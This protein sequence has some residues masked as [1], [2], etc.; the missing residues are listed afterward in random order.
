MIVISHRGASGYAPEN[1]LPAFE[2]AL[3]M[4]AKAFEFD[5]QR[6]KDGKLIVHH[7][8]DF[9][10]TAK[11]K[12]KIAQLDYK[13]IEKIN[14]AAHF[15]GANFAKVPLLSEVLDLIKD[16]SEFINLE[17]KNDGNIYPNIEADILKES[18]KFPSLK[19]KIIISSFYFPSLEKTRILSPS[20]RLAYLGH[21]LSAILIAPAVL[22]AKKINCE[23]FHLSRKISFSANLK[24]IKSFGFKVCVYTVN[25]RKEA[26]KLEKIGVYGIFSNYPDIMNKNG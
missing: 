13:E 21:K 19:E 11:D 3:Q 12:R 9:S 24:L 25:E 26:E 18:E 17:I 22:K 8:Y 16:K 10:R 5:V 14:A 23:N 6:S 7:D 20:A 1:T 15:K 2:K 4:G